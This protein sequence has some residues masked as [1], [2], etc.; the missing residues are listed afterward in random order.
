MEVNWNVLLGDL[1]T[2]VLR[3]FIP[4][5]IALVL[6][7]ASEIWMRIQEDKPDL[8]EVLQIAARIGYAAAES[9]FRDQDA[10]GEDKMDYAISRAEEYLK[11]LGYSIDLHVIRDAINDYGVSNWKFSWVKDEAFGILPPE[12]EED[13]PPIPEGVKG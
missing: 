11:E 2:Q 8:A 1:I 13:E 12:D 5:L 10:D 7:W 9:F 6:K 4:V 3:I